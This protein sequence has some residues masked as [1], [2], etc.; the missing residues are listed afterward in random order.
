MELQRRRHAVALRLRRLAL[1]VLHALHGGLVEIRPLGNVRRL[2]PEPASRLADDVAE[3]V[4]EGNGRHLRVA[5][6][7]RSS[8]SIS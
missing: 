8:S 5:H 6:S 7:A 4:L 1:V 2:E 3:L